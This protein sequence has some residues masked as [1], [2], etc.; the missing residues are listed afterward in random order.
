MNEKNILFQ[1]GKIGNLTLRN[2][3]FRSA[4]FEGMCDSHGVPTEK[5]LTLYTALAKN[6]IG[7]IITG[8]AYISDCDRAMQPGQAGIESD[9]KIVFYKRITDRVHSYHSRIFM[10]IAHC[11]R[12]T[13]AT[14]VGGVVRGASTKKSSY[15]GGAPKK[16]TTE[17]T[18]SLSQ[19][20]ADAAL[21]CKKS[22]F[23][24]VQ[25]HAAHGYLVHQ[26]IL[27][28]VNNRKDIFGIDKKT[29]IGTY[30]LEVIIDKVR[31]KCGSD[32]PLL[33]KI[34]AGDDYLKTFN[35]NHFIQLI[36]FLDGKKVDGI[37]ISY[38][39]MD[40]A[41]SIFR[42]QSIPLDLILRYTPRYQTQTLFGRVL[43]KR[44]IYPFMKPR[45]KM[46]TPMYNLLYA[47]IAKQHTQIP[48]ICVGGFRTKQEMIGAVE[49]KETDFVS[50]CRPFICEP[51]LV[52][53][54][55]SND[56]Y[57]AKCLDCN[58]CAVMC[59]SPN[60][61]RCYFGKAI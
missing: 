24:G 55:M 9:D 42:G 35:R 4:T 8:F 2:R 44:I 59:D 54:L 13:I 60:S 7:A 22:G 37:E 27:P 6:C 26:F 31:D 30:F 56:C 51:D 39:T 52:T 40:H 25:I 34:S 1:P 18:L 19:C 58:M 48:V 32:F 49:R 3:I 15:F 10:Q 57:K 45:I 17:E 43:R 38:G 46:F 61:T 16:L 29:G 33:I 36:R 50:L 11:G 21:R 47:K 12:Q 20:F 53:E 5:Y 14:A 41:L 23:D 28:S